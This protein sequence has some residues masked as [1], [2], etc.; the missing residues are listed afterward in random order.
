MI[1]LAVLTPISIAINEIGDGVTSQGF[2][3]FRFTVMRAKKFTSYVKLNRDTQSQP[4]KN[5]ESGRALSDP[6]CV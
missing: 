5:K 3:W 6:I 2:I 1:A 4:V